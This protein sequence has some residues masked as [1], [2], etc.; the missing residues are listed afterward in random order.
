M[1]VCRIL[2]RRSVN[3]GTAFMIGDHQS[4]TSDLWSPEGHYGDR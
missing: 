2:E 1:T 3:A 4:L